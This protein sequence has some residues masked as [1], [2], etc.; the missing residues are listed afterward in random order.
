MKRAYIEL[1]TAVL[2]FGF[3]AILGKLIS[4]DAVPLV[5]WR[6]LLTAASLL[7]FASVR[8]S[9]RELPLKTILQFVA[10]GSLL[11]LHWISFFLSIKL[12]NVSVALVAFSTTTFF[13]A[14]AEPLIVGGRVQKYELFLGLLIIPAMALIV[15]KLDLAFHLG[16]WIGIASAILIAIFTSI[17]K[18]MIT[19]AGPLQITFLQMSGALLFI[20]IFLPALPGEIVANVQIQGDDI[21]YMLLLALGCTTLAYVL[22]IRSLR[23]LTAFASNLTTSLEPIYGIIMAILIFKEH[24]SLPLGFYIGAAIILSAVFAYPVLRRRHRKKII[25]D[26]RTS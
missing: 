22:A 15:S 5:W 14:I 25:A 8:R 17:T 10:T 12:A 20:S 2:L 4:I 1:H 6:V 18:R 16:L 11:A 9:F 3:T 23:F 24:E 13:T 26:A 21:I 7:V 19:K